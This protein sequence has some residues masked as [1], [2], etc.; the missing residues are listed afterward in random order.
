[1]EIDL[2]A[3]NID[4]GQRAFVECKCLR[5]PLSA[6]VIDLLIGKAVRKKVKLAYVFSTSLLGKEAKGVLDELKLNPDKDIPTI[7]FVGPA[8]LVDMFI[9][10]YD[11]ERSIPDTVASASLIIS[12]H[13]EPFWVLEQQINGIPQR[14]VLRPL[15]RALGPSFAEMKDCLVGESLY[16]GLEFFSDDG[17]PT[18]GPTEAVGAR[19][20]SEIVTRITV[21]D[22]LDDYRPCRPQD[23]IGRHGIQKQVW[24][25]LKRV[26]DDTTGT[27]I[28][29][30]SGPSGYGK[31]SIVLKL[32]D[33]FRNQKW[34][35][36]FFLYPIDVRSAKG[37][38]FVAKAVRT[39]FQAAFDD[40]FIQHDFPTSVDIDS[41][42]S[43]LQSESIQLALQLLRD[44]RRVLVIFF[45]QFEEL[46]TCTHRR[47]FSVLA[48][49]TYLVCPFRGGCCSFTWKSLPC[50]TP[51]THCFA[52]EGSK[53][54]YAAEAIF[55]AERDDKAMRENRPA[56]KK[57]QTCFFV[58]PFVV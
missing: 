38:L 56:A 58:A 29:A 39:A 13:R 32:A 49:G 19:S 34:A 42:E 25:F 52:G 26:R 21:A 4:T 55:D 14:A 23:F 11:A 5:E 6:N 41:A 1:M 37:P 20:D 46:F 22:A 30:L 50:G 17:Q 28:L 35:T 15:S 8:S 57:A 10:V 54:L 27:R 3:D 47:D 18:I 45:D 53:L 51:R 12:P 48:E 44:S 40:S 43:I 24:D 31:S 7:A 36:K 33:R 16:S 9:D 2:I